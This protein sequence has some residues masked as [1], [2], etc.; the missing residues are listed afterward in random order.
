MAFPP[1]WGIPMRTLLIFFALVLP[2]LRGQ[3]PE[4]RTTAKDRTAL[5]VTIYQNGLA[6][7]RDTRRVSLPAGLSRLAIVDLLPTL[8]PKSATLLDSG[9]GFQVRERNF[10]FNLLSP[11]SLVDVSLGLPVRIKR[12]EGKLRQEG[13]LVSV[14][15]LNP[16]F[17]PDA[18]P[19]ERIARKASAYAQA[20]DP[21]VVVSTP[22]GLRIGG[23][24][25][26]SF[27][28]LP[29]ALRPSPTL[30]QDISLPA[31]S[32][33]AV[34]LLYTA[35]DFAW[36]PF[37]IAT[38]ASD[39]RHMDLDVLATVKNQSGG[40]LPGTLLQL[41]AGAPNMV[42]DPPPSNQNTPQVDKTEAKTAV[43]VE[44]LASAP[45]FREEKLS[46]YPLFTL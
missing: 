4:I 27:L 11:A 31:A 43:V 8:R 9:N 32:D 1:C 33:A 10:E 7:V 13:I 6:A 42:Y 14:P 16:R 30:L 28:T 5:S 15:L 19:L 46:E 34:T 26:V 2:S 17:R 37:Y 12:E 44:V 36:T 29:S 24:G 3:S 45:V 39:G 21:G 40:E 22:E 25:Q 38:L 41:V 18:K 20:P 35:T 23:P